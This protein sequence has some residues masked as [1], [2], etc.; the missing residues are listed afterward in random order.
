[1]NQVKATDHSRGVTCHLQWNAF[2][3][4]VLRSRSS[5]R[6]LA[7]VRLSYSCT[8]PARAFTIAQRVDRLES[9]PSLCGI[10]VTHRPH[11]FQFTRQ[12]N[13]AEYHRQRLGISTTSL[14][15]QCWKSGTSTC[16][17]MRHRGGFTGTC[18]MPT[19]ASRQSRIVFEYFKDNQW[20]WKRPACLTSPSC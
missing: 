17:D 15:R 2:G 20:K 8:I 12:Q 18:V 10:S 14:R 7:I 1:M 4:D 19:T 9:H 6:C 13:V 3:N 5:K 11:R 16:A